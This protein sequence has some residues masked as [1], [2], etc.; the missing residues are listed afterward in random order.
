MWISVNVNIQSSTCSS[1]FSN[2]VLTFCKEI[3]FV[4]AMISIAILAQTLDLEEQVVVSTLN[5][6]GVASVSISMMGRMKRKIRILTELYEQETNNNNVL[7]VK[8][9]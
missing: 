9:A 6:R 5:P 3:L 4:F 8:I 1:L 7:V 2:D